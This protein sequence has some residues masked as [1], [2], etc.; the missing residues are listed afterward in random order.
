[1]CNYTDIEWVHLLKN[2]PRPAEVDRCLWEEVYRFCWFQVRSLGFDEQLATDCAVD[3]FTRIVSH[4]SSF[5]FEC[6]F[7]AWW[8]VIAAN[9]VKTLGERAGRRTR[10]E[11]SFPEDEADEPGEAASFTDLLAPPAT[12]LQR[13][14]PCLEALRQRH[15]QVIELRYLVQNTAGEFVEQTVEAVAAQLNLTP[16]NVAV[17][18]ARARAALRQCLEAREFLDADDVLRL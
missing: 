8:R 6:S 14:R 5:R 15:R 3:A 7:R 13:L 10:R 9:R 16:G 1:M 17:I 4:I 11:A 18:A 2:D 12:I